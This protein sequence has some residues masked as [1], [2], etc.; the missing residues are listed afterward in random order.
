MRGRKIFRTVRPYVSAGAAI[1][2]AGALV[3]T[4]YFTRFDLEWVA[5]LTGILVAA[6]L[7]VATRASHA[8][9]VVSRRSAQLASAKDK[10]ER[11]TRLRKE[12]EDSIAASKPRLHLIDE[13]ISDMVAL[14]DAEGHNRYHNR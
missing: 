9:W 1:A 14:V 3:F 7:A 5:F 11:E 4:I 8:E 6:I 2:A 10:L 12:A 13:A